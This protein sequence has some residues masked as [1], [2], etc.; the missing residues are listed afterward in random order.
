M[1][2]SIGSHFDFR[3]TLFQEIRKNLVEMRTRVETSHRR[4]KSYRNTVFELSQCSD[5]DL[6][7]LGIARCDIRRLARE[8]SDLQLAKEG[9]DA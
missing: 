7:D 1:S 2:L 8:N 4:W 6:N 3:G 9:W 5:R